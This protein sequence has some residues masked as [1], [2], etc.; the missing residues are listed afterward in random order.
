MRRYLVPLFVLPVSLGAQTLPPV[1][2]VARV[3]DSL[4]AAF[5]AERSAPS[6]AIAVVRGRDTVVMRAWGKADIEQDLA[7]TPRSVYRIGSMTKQFT[8]S[9]IMQLVEQGKVKLDQSIGTYLPTLPVAWRGVTV[10]QLLNHTSGIPSYT[11]L[12][13]AWQRRWGEEMTPD[14]LVA[15]TANVPMAFAPGTQWRYDNSGYVVLGMLIEKITGHSWATDIAERFTRPLGLEDTR[16]CPTT[17]IIPRRVRGYESTGNGWVNA[18][19]LAMSQPYSAGAMC[20]TVG[21]IAKWNRALHTGHVV[22]PASYTMMT[23]PE[24]AAANSSYGFGLAQDTAAGRLMIV[25]GGGINGFASGNAW[26]PSAELSITVLA[27]AS[28]ARSDDLVKQLARA[29][30]GAPLEQP[31][32]VVPLAAGDRQRFVGVYTLALPNGPRDLTV[33]VQG[34]Q[35]TA[36]LTG[37]GPIQLLYLGDNTFGVGFDRNLRLIFTI[38][39]ERATKVTLVQGGGRFEGPR[40]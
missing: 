1:A 25:H 13:P 39:G 8:S 17:P 11:D 27:N 15:L 40:K 31:L 35:L 19:Y 9:A 3:A 2:S 37:Q 16:D 21:D 32:Q 7:A 29:A 36:Q 23:T 18:A 24:G 22:S 10:R 12:G 4:A 14:T 30:L 26:V 6:V 5:I 34:D 33:A 28:S 20:S 38:Q